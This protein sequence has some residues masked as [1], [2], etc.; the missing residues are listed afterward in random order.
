MTAILKTTLKATFWNRFTKMLARWRTYVVNGIL[1]L[2]VVLPELIHSPEIMA[3]IPEEYQRWVV[4]LGFVIN[5]WMRPRPAVLPGDPEVK[6]KKEA[7][8]AG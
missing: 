7:R 8:H 4:A 5:I 3:L 1:I 6:A 2:L